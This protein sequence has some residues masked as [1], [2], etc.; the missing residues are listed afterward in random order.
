LLAV[1]GALGL[2]SG[3]GGGGGGAPAPA[4]IS[5]QN[6][7]PT[8]APIADTGNSAYTYETRIQPAIADADGDMLTLSVSVGDDGIATGSVDSRTG[9]IVLHPLEPGRTQAAVTVSDAEAAASRVFSYEVG[10]VTKS[11]AVEALPDGS[12]AITLSNTA[13]SPV[14]FVLTHNGFRTFESIPDMIEFVG[15]MPAQFAGEPFEQKLWR[16]LRDNVYHAPFLN[17]GPWLMS[18]TVL[19]NSMGFGLCST[20]AAAYVDL[21]RAA[22]YEGR[23]WALTG[24]VVPEIRIGGAWQMFDSDLAVY[25]RRHDASVAGVSELS[26]DRSLITTP[27]NPLFPDGTFVGYSGAVADIYTSDADNFV[28]SSLLD[29]PEGL[30]GRLTLPPRAKLT[31]QGR[32]T[33]PP[34]AYGDGDVPYEVSQFEQAAMTLADGWIGTVAL[35]WVVW[36]VRGEGQVRIDGILYALGSEDLR[37]RL[38]GS[39]AAINQLEIVAS[40]GAATIIFLVNPLRYEIASSNWIELTGQNVWQVQVQAEPLPAQYRAGGP[41]PADQRKPAP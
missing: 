34:L 26:A 11:V 24:H 1:L 3:C 5:A 36:D 6:H 12:E 38:R 33:E 32:W 29:L 15:S 8:L 23:I 16:F 39:D 28:W 27:V 19:V 37:Q 41:F 35:P 9:E 40:S 22:G 2:V 20:V 25:Y 4:A 30:P 14:D 17:P 13:D 21:A 18:P 7:G 10:E 31:Y